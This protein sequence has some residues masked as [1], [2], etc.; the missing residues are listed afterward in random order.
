MKEA[1]YYKKLK[2]KIVQCQLCPRFCTIKEDSKGN[3]GVRINKNGNLYSLVYEKPCTV[4]VDKIEKKPLYHFLPVT[5][6]FSIA[7]AGCNLHCLYCQNWEISQCK[8]EEISH[9]D[10]TSEE[11]VKKAI[12]EKCKSISYTYTE[13]TI[14]IEYFLD[15]AKLARKNKLKNIIVSN[16]FINKEPLKDFCKYLDAANIDLKSFDDKFYKELTTASL[17]SILNTLKILKEN[18]VWLEITN[19]II[20]KKNDNIEEIKKMCTWIKD[21]LGE[22]TPLHFSRFFPMYKML[23]IKPTPKETL[24]K[25]KEIALKTGLKYIYIGNINIENSENTYCSKCKKLLIERMGFTISQNNIKNGKCTC[26][27]KISGIWS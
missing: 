16:G 15:I 7:T 12:E 3:C 17:K 22:N 18:N 21:N 20:P 14:A 9:L 8:P 24:L 27:K 26:G 6:I 19:L 4:H 23:N 11:I 1:S 5:N 10:L 13:P 25:A 2:N